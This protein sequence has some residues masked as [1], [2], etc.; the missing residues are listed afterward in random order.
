MNVPFPF[1]LPVVY[2]AVHMAPPFPRAG[3]R[4]RDQ[5]ARRKALLYTNVRLRAEEVERE[6]LLRHTLLRLCHMMLAWRL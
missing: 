5:L 1:G 3:P 4:P 2:T 6:V